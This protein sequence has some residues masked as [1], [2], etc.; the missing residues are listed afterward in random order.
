MVPN[1]WLYLWRTVYLIRWLVFLIDLSWLLLLIYRGGHWENAIGTHCC[2]LKG[3]NS[4]C[5]LIRRGILIWWGLTIILRCLIWVQKCMN[6]EFNIGLR[7]K[8]W[9]FKYSRIKKIC[10]LGYFSRWM[11]KWYLI[12][13]SYWPVFNFSNTWLSG[14]RRYQIRKSL[15]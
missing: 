11:H 14:S 5:G 3:C 9:F 8:I 13:N 15:L 10:N 7:I 6:M 2:V 1:S 4:I 12:W